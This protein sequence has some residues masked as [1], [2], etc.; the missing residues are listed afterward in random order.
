MESNK[1]IESKI[2]DFLIEFDDCEFIIEAKEDFI[3]IEIEN[4]EGKH[5]VKITKRDLDSYNNTNWGYSG[6]RKISD[7]IDHWRIIINLVDFCR[8]YFESIK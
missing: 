1:T 3:V 5:Q 2:D 6:S 4:W 8:E 7:Y